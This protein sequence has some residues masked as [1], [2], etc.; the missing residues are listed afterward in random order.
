M[1]TPTRE[2]TRVHVWLFKDD[3]EFLRLHYGGQDQ[4][5]FSRIVRG[6]VSKFVKSTRESLAKGATAVALKTDPT[7]LAEVPEDD[8]R[9]DGQ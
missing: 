1:A 7:V 3:V 2:T 8:G 5:G 6:V 9:K 4:V